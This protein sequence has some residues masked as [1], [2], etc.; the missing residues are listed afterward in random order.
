[1]PPP[2][3]LEKWQLLRCLVWL[4]KSMKS[5]ANQWRRGSLGRTSDREEKAYEIFLRGKLNDN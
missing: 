3:Q 1:M 2:L 4:Q 5:L